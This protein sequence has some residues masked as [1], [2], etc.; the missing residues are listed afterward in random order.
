MAGI[1]NI[2][3]AYNVNTNKSHKKISFKLGEKFSAKIINIDELTSEAMLKLL[4]GWEFSAQIKGKFDSIPHELIKFEVEGY[5]DGKILL[6]I[7][8][9]IDGAEDNSIINTLEKKGINVKKEDFSILKKMLKYNMPLTKDNISKMKSLLEFQNK[10]IQDPIE[11]DNFIFKYIDN[12]GI[13]LNSEKGQNT[14]K[15]LKGFFKEFKNLKMDEMFTLIENDIE[16]T[17]GNIKS[18]N[19]INKEPMAIYKN[20]KDMTSG[21]EIKDLV[22]LKEI[23]NKSENISLKNFNE[24]PKADEGTSS[25]NLSKNSYNQKGYTSENKD[26]DGKEILRRLLELDSTGESV[27][28][29]NGSKVKNDVKSTKNENPSNKNIEQNISKEDVQKNDVQ[30]LELQKSENI[31]KTINKTNKT[32]IEISDKIKEEFDSKIN[33]MKNIIKSILGEKDSSKPETFSS[34][35]QNI[36]SK[37][38][39]FKIFNSLSN[40]YYYLDVPVNIDDRKYPCKL[41]VKDDRKNGKK[42][43]STNAKFVVSVKTVN[44]GS[45]DT[46]IKFTNYNINL[47]IKCEKE[48]VKVLELSKGKIINKLES[49]GYMVNAKIDEKQKQ[50]DLIECKSF[51]EDNGF[52]RIN[53]KV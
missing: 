48:W 26:I 7:L 16:L 42:I 28:S 15:L 44:M 39:D 13:D 29:D 17:E 49:M 14:Q 51:F 2:N 46:Y 3:N 10:I 11:E 20:I 31:D 4:D 37:M 6:K 5:E 12:K 24:K 35:I 22:N 52:T 23:E 47:D 38:N 50:A 27:E 21:K 8:N 25:N 32:S 33:E 19:K 41:I 53:Q 18:F 40:Q 34:I 36:N 43:D 9:D 1:M 45:V 30:K